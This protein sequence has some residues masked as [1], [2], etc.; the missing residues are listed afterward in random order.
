MK[1]IIL[2]TLFFALILCI[3]TVNAVE[4]KVNFGTL[5]LPTTPIIHNDRTLVP[6]RP[7][8][9]IFGAE[10]DWNSS[11][12]VTIDYKDNEIILPINAKQAIVN[13]KIIELDS[14]AILYNGYTMVPLKFLSDYFDVEVEWYDED[15]IV[16]ILIEDEK[17][18]K[19][20]E[21]V[22]RSY[23]RSSI[24]KGYKVVIDAGH[25]GNETG[26]YYN[27]I[28]EKNINISI[29]KY[30]EELLKKYDIAVYMT[31]KNDVTTTLA[32]RTDLAN[33]VKAD[34][35]V[36][37]HSNAIVGKPNI[38]GTELLYK[39]NYLLKKGVTNKILANNLQKS[40]VKSAGTFDKGLIN[41]TNLFVLNHANMP[42]A[43]VEVGY[44][45]NET[46]LK[47][48]NSDSFRKKV[49]E[50]IVDGILKTLDIMIDNE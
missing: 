47:K 15:R 25:G 35:F 7:L 5:S 30:V 1:K 2:L 38:K 13:N 10:V 45:T 21:E 23:G 18:I 44:M 3:S 29:A 27:G 11:G 19:K 9:E 40:V 32:A 33:K 12:I 50:G 42:A 46:E 36:S 8:A 37:I 22:S 43:L 34:L 6:L 28:A 14:G 41:R 20:V 48:L 39:D 17:I 16:N 4:V 49:A 24:Y 31:R 26:A